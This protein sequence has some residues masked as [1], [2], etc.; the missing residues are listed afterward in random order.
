MR[1]RRRLLTCWAPLAGLALLGACG[2]KHTAQELQQQA[3]A[4]LAAGD[5]QSHN[6]YIG[7]IRHFTLRFSHSHDSVRGHEVK[8]RAR[9]N[10]IDISSTCWKAAAGT[11]SAVN[12]S[13]SPALVVNN[14]LGG[15]PSVLL[16]GP[17]RSATTS[18]IPSPD[19]S[20]RPRTISA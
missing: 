4:R 19:W 5:G 3:E 17:G 8:S 18:A 2:E 10:V 11:W 16:D 12:R 15:A 20:I 1:T 13:K 9:F 14:V 7:N 6:I